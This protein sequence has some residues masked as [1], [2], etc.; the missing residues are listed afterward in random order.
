MMENSTVIRPV[1]P[2]SPVMA[3]PAAG[4]VDPVFDSQRV[5]RTILDCVARPGRLTPLN[6]SVGAPAPLLATTAEILLAMADFETSIWLDDRLAR[7][8][9]VAAFLRF[10]TGARLV[11][12]PAQ[13]TFAV[14]SD[15][16]SM[17]AL[18]T[19]GQGTPDYPDRSTTLLIQVER[20]ESS[21]HAFEGAGINGRI[22]FAAEPAPPDF[23]NQLG[24]N[25]AA[26]PCGVDLIFVTLA[27][28]A[29]LPRSVRL[30]KG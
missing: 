21:G 4:F 20:L 12:D 11:N 22:A 27:T 28:V 16:A 5:F 18:K 7:T 15:V 23:F 24:E 8:V 29:A 30:V 10:H 26:F 3:A 2:Q 14:I 17:P 19:F 1:P 9:E 25:R 6:S 13:A